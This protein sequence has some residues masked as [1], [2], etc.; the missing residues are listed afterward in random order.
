MADPLFGSRSQFLMDFEQTFG[1]AKGTTTP[2]QIAIVSEALSGT[3]NLLTNPSIRAD[4]NRPA[5]VNGHIAA[6]GTLQF[7]ST[8]DAA[9]WLLKLFFH[10]LAASGSSPNYISTFKWDITSVT[11][12]SAIMQVKFAASIYKRLTGC[13]IKKI[14]IKFMSEGF[15]MWAIDVVAL[16][17]TSQTSDSLP[18][19]VTDWSSSTPF[20]MLQIAAADLKINTVASTT[21]GGNA[22]CLREFEI[23]ANV[24]ITEDDYRIAQAGARSGL[25]VGVLDLGVKMKIAVEGATQMTFM[26][27]GT[28]ASFDATFT[29]AASR[30]LRLYVPAFRVQKTLPNISDDMGVYV[31]VSGKAEYDATAATSFLAVVTTANDPSV[32]Y[33]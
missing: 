8:I 23:D 15:L 2:K 31:E 3:Q 11:F 26:Q 29:A 7:V 32:S 14:N 19:T 28:A 24:N 6:Q 18:G 5:S 20:E 30:T 10:T 13:R 4:G 17:A 22:A 1:A 27:A 12:Q 16:T 9:P 21:S 25:P 33:V